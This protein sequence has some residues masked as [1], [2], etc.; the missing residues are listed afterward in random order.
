LQDNNSYRLLTVKE[1]SDKLGLKIQSGNLGLNNVI[2]GGY[3]TDLLSDALGYSRPK[4]VWITIQQHKNVMAIA[5]LKNLSAVILA[6]GMIPDQ[7]TIIQSNIENIPILGSD[8][9]SFE[10]IGKLYGLLKIDSNSSC[11]NR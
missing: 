1:L 4:Q 6:K 2:E 10:L 11:S 9:E 7:D 5:V 3:A 8:L